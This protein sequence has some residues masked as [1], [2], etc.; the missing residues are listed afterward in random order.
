MTTIAGVNTSYSSKSNKA[1]AC[2]VYLSYP[3]LNVVYKDFLI[4]EQDNEYKCGLLGERECPAYIELVNKA[5]YKPDIIF[6]NGNGVLHPKRYGSACRLGNKLDIKSV[7]IGKT[8]VEGIVTQT[9]VTM[10]NKTDDLVYLKTKKGEI[11]GAAYR[12]NSKNY[13]YISVG[14]KITLE[15]SIELTSKICKYRLPEPSRQAYILSHNYLSMHEFE[16]S[17]PEYFDK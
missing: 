13:V 16:L 17:N 3:E 12:K 14:N 2:L 7:G 1:V 8:L 11:L 4:Y 9:Q 10:K 5:P 15:E 6:V